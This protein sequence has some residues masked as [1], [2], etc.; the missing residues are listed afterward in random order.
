[1][2]SQAGTVDP[3]ITDITKNDSAIIC[4]LK[5]SDLSDA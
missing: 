2:G 4:H 1:M 5:V 3:P